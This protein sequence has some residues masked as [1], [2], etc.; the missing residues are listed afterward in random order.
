MF[1]SRSL[2]GSEQIRNSQANQ[3]FCWWIIVLFIRNQRFSQLWGTKMWKRLLFRLIQ[4]KSSRLPIPAYLTS[5]RGK[6]NINYHSPMT[7]SLRTLFET[8]F[9]H[10]SKHFFEIMSE[11]YLNCLDLNL[12]LFKLRT[13][14]CFERTNCVEVRDPRRLGKLTMPWT[15]SPKDAEKGD[16]DGSI[17]MSRANKSSFSVTLGTRSENICSWTF[18]LYLEFYWF[19]RRSVWWN[20]YFLLFV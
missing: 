20:L 4:L 7:I 12:I 14:C 1:W 8:P 19:R 15:N 16:M 9:T 13:H 2:R 6:C 17:K 11:V 5:S 18:T 3:Q 10:W